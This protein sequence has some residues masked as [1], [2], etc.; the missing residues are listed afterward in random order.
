MFV[1]YWE[2]VFIDS[3]FGS[4]FDLERFKRGLRSLLEMIDNIIGDEDCM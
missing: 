2:F 4:N 1:S 3:V